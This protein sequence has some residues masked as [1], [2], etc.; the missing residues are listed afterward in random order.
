M[1]NAATEKREF[2]NYRQVRAM[3]GKPLDERTALPIGRNGKKEIPRKFHLGTDEVKALKELAEAGDKFP[4]PHSKGFYHYLIE[5]LKSLGI[6]R[7]F[8]W[9]TVTDKFKEI[10]S[11]TKESN[12]ETWWKNWSQKAPRNPATGRDWQGKFEENVEVMQRSGGLTP[13]G[14][15]ILEV[16]TRVLGTDGAVIDILRNAQGTAQ[17]RLNTNSK[18]PINQLRNCDKKQGKKAVSKK[19]G[20]KTAKKASK[21]IVP[22]VEAPAIDVPQIE[23]VETVATSPET[24]TV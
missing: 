18:E 10:T 23:A 24:A 4:N 21:K 11:A 16:G 9:S 22:T 19:Q 5:T 6:N 17:I 13:Y 15:K 2:T 3:A 12:G 1:S 7:A 14:L 8:S 20:K